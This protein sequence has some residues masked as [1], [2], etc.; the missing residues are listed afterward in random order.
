[1]LS[2]L[3]GLPKDF[4]GAE[5]ASRDDY[6]GEGYYHQ[7]VYHPKRADQLRGAVQFEGHKDF[8]LVTYLLRYVYVVGIS[9]SVGSAQSTHCRSTG[10][11]RG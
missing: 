8:G 1:M 6:F 10:P 5:I 7:M 2:E 4:L 11:L 9:R 3:L